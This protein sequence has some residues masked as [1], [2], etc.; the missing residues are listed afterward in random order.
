M[1]SEQAVSEQ[2]VSAHTAAPV[3]RSWRRWAAIGA[4]L[5]ALSVLAGAFGAHG[6]RD[7]LEPRA[8]DQ[9][10]TAARYLMYAGLGT[11]LSGLM[12]RIGADWARLSAAGLV[13]GGLIFFLSVGGLALGGPRQLGAVAPVGGLGMIVGFVLLAVAALRAD[14]ADG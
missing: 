12:A 14:P 8:L 9:W 1:A 4:V 11:V 6:L 3:Q 2:A 13:A 5:A 10:Q 7:R